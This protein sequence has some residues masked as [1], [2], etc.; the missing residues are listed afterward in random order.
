MRE[1]ARVLKRGGRLVIVDSLQLGDEP[2]YD[3]ML[4]LFPQ[5]YHLET[6]VGLRIVGG[7]MPPKYNS[8]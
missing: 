2:R 4:D 5:T 3:G 1:F 8:Y 7:R 6:V